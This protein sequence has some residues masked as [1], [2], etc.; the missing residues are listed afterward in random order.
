MRQRIQPAFT[1]V[2]VMISIAIVLVLMLGINYIFGAVS[3]TAS[4]G[5]IISRLQRDAR[6]AQSVMTDDFKGYAGDAPGLFI[7]SERIA[8]FRNKADELS[9]LDYAAVASGTE[10]QIDKAIRTVDFDNNNSEADAGDEI[11]P[12]ILGL[13]NFRA[14]RLTYFARGSFR[15]QTGND[16]S[17]IAPQTCTE[18]MIWLGQLRQAGDPAAPPGTGVTNTRNLGFRESGAT[19]YTAS[20]N[21]NNFY[22]SQWALGRWA[23]LLQAP[24]AGVITDRNGV[25]QTYIGRQLT[26]SGSSIAPLSTMLVVP[27]PPPVL[28]AADFA[29]ATQDGTT[30]TAVANARPTGWRLADCRYDIAGTSMSA[31]SQIALAASA[32]SAMWYNQLLDDRLSA[33]ALPSRPLD[34]EG[35]SR[36]SPVLMGGCS[37]FIVEYAGDFVTQN[38]DATDVTDTT[39]SPVVLTD[40]LIGDVLNY[41]PNTPSADGVLDFA[42]DFTDTNANGAMD[43]AEVGSARKRIRWYGFPRDINGDGVINGWIANRRNAALP[44]VVPLRDVIRSARAA[45]SNTGVAAF[46]RAVNTELLPVTNYAALTGL[47]GPASP[48]YTCAWGPDTAT[49]PRPRLIRITYTLDDAGGSLRDGQ[50]FEYIF[51]LP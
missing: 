8:A 45:D 47:A 30:F 50:T 39:N 31:W 20:T 11:P 10:I 13:R 7:R 19:R 14:D 24:T 43:A 37:S 23:V 41:T 48:R 29:I 28:T 26:A 25:A 17:F 4:T 15:R 12:A 16:G 3:S 18:A 5:Q 38:N 51:T 1:L 40:G 2:E 21:P 34:S 44:D 33:S 9:D 27:T 49:S 42:V 32:S 36:S 22:A 35:V 6:G 46:E